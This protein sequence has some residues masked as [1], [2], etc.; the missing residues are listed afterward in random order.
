MEFD[1]D[2]EV[3]LADMEFN[4]DDDHESERELKLQVARIYNWKLDQRNERKRHVIDRGLVDVKKQQAYEK[5]LT[6]E[7]KELVCRLRVFSRLQSAQEHEAL[8]E[9]ILRARKLR[10]HIELLQYYRRMGI[11]AI[12]QIRRFESERKKREVD[13]RSSNSKSSSMDPT[14]ALHPAAASST[15]NA[16]SRRRIKLSAHDAS[17]DVSQHSDMLIDEDSASSSVKMD[18]SRAPGVEMLSAIEVDF[19]TASSLLPLHYLAIKEVLVR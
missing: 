6:K 18:L 10:S 11:R 4:L 1:N 15:A 12:D 13:P 3:I 17:K 14:H 8:V 19:C 7:E 9:G 5:R 2:A 16:Q